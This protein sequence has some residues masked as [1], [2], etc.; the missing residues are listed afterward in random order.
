MN[1]AEQ[2]LVIVLAAFL[3]LFI[4]LSIALVVTLMKLVKKMHMVADDAQEI[5][6][7]A[8]E[9]AGKVDSVSDMFKKTAGPLAFGKFFINMAETV[10]KHKRE[11]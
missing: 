9:I 4:G 6:G 8:R 5:V 7:K 1:T 11:K 10:A 2:I 3:A